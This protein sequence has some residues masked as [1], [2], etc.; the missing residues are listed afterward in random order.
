M[1]GAFCFLPANS[2]I[3]LGD[4]CNAPGLGCASP[5]TPPHGCL[6]PRGWAG[7]DGV[8]GVNLLFDLL[9]NQW[10]SHWS[11]SLWRA[12]RH[13][14]AVCYHTRS[15]PV[16]HNGHKALLQPPFSPRLWYFHQLFPLWHPE[17]AP[18]SVVIIRRLKTATR[19]RIFARA[20]KDCGPP[21]GPLTSR[22]AAILRGSC[23][24]MAVVW[25]SGN[26]WCQLCQSGPFPG[27]DTRDTWGHFSIF[28]RATAAKNA[29]AIALYLSH[30]TAA[31]LLRK[32]RPIPCSGMQIIPCPPR[33]TGEFDILNGL[34]M[35]PWKHRGQGSPYPCLPLLL[36]TVV[37]GP[38]VVVITEKPRSSAYGRLVPL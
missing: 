18:D 28:R 2:H 37:L 7:C 36:I 23:Y 8:A 11:P 5:S 35:T 38:G 16:R 24:K 15:A 17:T 12:G 9:L 27:E 20:A 6:V 25:L 29:G 21:A 14:L 19:I 26:I 34:I 31:I 4:G 13:C 33:G 3:N 22:R 32:R 10:V 1:T 30:L